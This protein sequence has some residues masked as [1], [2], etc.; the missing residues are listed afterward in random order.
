MD[1]RM[2]RHRAGDGAKLIAAIT[3]AGIGFVVARTWAGDRNFERQLKRRKKSRE[4]CPI[5]REERRK[6]G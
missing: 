2:A 6:N 4:L 1:S 5:C 3:K